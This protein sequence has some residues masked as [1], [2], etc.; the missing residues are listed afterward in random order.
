VHWGTFNLALHAWDQPA[1]TLF[2]LAPKAGVQLIMPRLGE[3]KEPASSEQPAP[4]WR[5]V[6][7][8]EDQR[9]PEQPAETE[10]PKEMPWPID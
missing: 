4:W 1:E 9:G 7:L 8:V 6:E 3:P 5:S 10:L 2:E